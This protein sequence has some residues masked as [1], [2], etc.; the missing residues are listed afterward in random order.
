MDRDMQAQGMP[1][2]VP[3]EV[4]TR[5]I[6]PVQSQGKPLPEVPEEVPPRQDAEVGELAL[7]PQLLEDAKFNA[8]IDEED[9]EEDGVADD[10]Y[11]W[12]AAGLDDEDADFN[13]ATDKEEDS[14]DDDN[15][16]RDADDLDAEEA[17]RAMQPQSGRWWRPG[18]NI[19]NVPGRFGAPPN[20]PNTPNTLN[21]PNTPNTPNTSSF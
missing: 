6:P 4:P 11:L 15:C 7:P 17:E 8:A 16:F 2:Q 5:E 19:P 20:T 21:T 3:G 18:P 9:E 14:V 1:E 10:D 13:A 12:D